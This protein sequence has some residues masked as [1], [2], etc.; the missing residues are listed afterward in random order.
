MCS[1]ERDDRLGSLEVSAVAVMENL[2]TTVR[3]RASRTDRVGDRV[4][5][6]RSRV[7]RRVKCSNETE[8][9]EE[10]GNVGKRDDVMQLE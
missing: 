5:R 8:P 9:S 3:L 7:R 10:S 4:E 1:S 2:K 6:Q